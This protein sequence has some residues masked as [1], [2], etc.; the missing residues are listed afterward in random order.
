MAKYTVKN[1]SKAKAIEN[2]VP[3]LIADTK[4]AKGVKIIRFRVL[5]YSI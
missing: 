3:H 5:N 2:I 1:I 4:E